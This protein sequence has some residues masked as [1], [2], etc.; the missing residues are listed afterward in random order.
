MNDRLNRK[1][2]GFLSALCALLITGGVAHSQTSP[3]FPVVV[4]A[5]S[6]SEIQPCTDYGSHKSY[7]GMP[8]YVRVPETGKV[9]R[10]HKG[11]DFCTDP[12][13]AVISA[14][15]GTI[16]YVSQDNPHRG[17]R[18]IVRTNITYVDKGSS[19]PSTLFLDHLHI[20]PKMAIAVG[21]SV[22]AGQV[23]GHTQPPGKSEIG[24]RSHVHFAAGPII[25]TWLQHTD[26]NQFW[27][28]GPG[29]V[30]CFDP[31]DPPGDDKIVAPI[32]C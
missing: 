20:T 3:D 6:Q 16:A 25:R 13:A 8:Y 1:F 9:T 7:S 22:R 30:S 17:G 23:I 21:D 31:S 32:R 26:P 5:S 11:I 24:P 15:N 18:V 14:A 12:G 27:Q 28:K 4:G 10:R 29:V 2:G 19:R